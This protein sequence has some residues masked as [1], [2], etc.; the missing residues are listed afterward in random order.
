MKK[1]TEKILKEAERIK[2]IRIE[3]IEG[4]K[5]FIKRMALDIP[6]INEEDCEP[7]IRPEWYEDNYYEYN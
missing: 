3:I 7:E 1:E 4:R 5:E 6:D 2:K